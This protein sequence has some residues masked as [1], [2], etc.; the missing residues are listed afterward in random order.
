MSWNVLEVGMRDLPLLEKRLMTFP[1]V[2]DYFP[3]RKMQDFPR[4]AGPNLCGEIA[5]PGVGGMWGG[6]APAG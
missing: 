1:W 2:P 6:C 4:A 5:S 3:D